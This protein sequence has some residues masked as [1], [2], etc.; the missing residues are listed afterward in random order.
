MQHFVE[1]FQFNSGDTAWH[2]NACEA[3]H[4]LQELTNELKASAAGLHLCSLVS[5]REGEEGQKSAVARGT[6][7]QNANHCG[8]LVHMLL[9]LSLTACPSA[10]PS[11]GSV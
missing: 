11:A 9:Q 6:R 7:A 8:R 5:G 2:G 10:S 1:D 4:T 3:R